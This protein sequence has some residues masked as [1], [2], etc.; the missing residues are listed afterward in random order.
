MEVP[1]E[2]SKSHAGAVVPFMD[3]WF[4]IFSSMRTP[5]YAKKF[6]TSPLANSCTIRDHLLRKYM[7]KELLG[8]QI[9]SISITWHYSPT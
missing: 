7:T 4:Q 6:R 1:F 2:G 5:S 9:K 8:K 3:K